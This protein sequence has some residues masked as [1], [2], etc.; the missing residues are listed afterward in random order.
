M[1]LQS[2][3]SCTSRPPTAAAGFLL[4]D[5][6]GH[7]V[8]FPQRFHPQRLGGEE[9][10]TYRGLRLQGTTMHTHARKQSV[11]SISHELDSCAHVIYKK[12]ACIVIRGSL[13]TFAFAVLIKYVQQLIDTIQHNKTG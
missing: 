11:C 2:R 12:T 13:A 4:T 10:S 7:G 1:S 9:H 8:P 5:S 3:G 6:T